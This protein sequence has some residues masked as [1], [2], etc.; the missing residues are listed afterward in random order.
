MDDLI[1]VEKP[2]AFDFLDNSEIENRGTEMK[3][4]TNMGDMP[5]RFS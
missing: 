3:K 1:L 2:I 5:K 4:A